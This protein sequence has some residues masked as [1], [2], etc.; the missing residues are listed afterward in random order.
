MRQFIITIAGVLVGLLL[1]TVVAAIWLVTSIAGALN[2]ASSQTAPTP[3]EVV[4]QLDLR[5]TIPDQRGGAG[6]L[7]GGGLNT[8]EIVRK[9]DAAAADPKVKGVYVRA[10]TGGLDPAQTEEIRSALA[11]IR[12][13]KKF[14][15]THMQNDGESNSLLGY[16]A[17][18]GSDELWLQ[19]TGDFMPMGILSQNMYLGGALQKF[20]VQAQ[21]EAREQYKDAVT[22]YTETA[23]TPASKE[24]TTAMLASIY[25]TAIAD[26]A[27]DRGMT[28]AAAKAAI[29]GSPYASADAV[30]LHLAD[31]LG[32]PEDAAQ[33]ALDRAGGKAE[34]L[35]L[36]RY[37][38]PSKSGGAT[39]A[40]VAAE[41]EIVSGPA[42]GPSFGGGGNISSDEISQAL[43][44]AAD[45]DDVKAIVF[46]VSSPGGSAVASDQ[47]SHAVALARQK[48]KKIVVSM[49]PY[50]ASGGYYI[51]AGADS[52]VAEPTTITGSIGIFGGKIVIGPALEHYLGVTTATTSVGSPNIAMFDATSPFT[53]QQRAV[54]AQM[55]DRGYADF[56]GVVAKG[57]H[58]SLDQVHDIAKGRVWTGAQAKERGLVDE[59]GGL[60][61]AI[62]RAKALAGLKPDAKISLKL[63]PQARNPIEELRSLFGVSGE[64]ARA[65][66]AL[67]AIL[68]DERVA[69]AMRAAEID[70]GGLRAEA[71]PM[72]V[73]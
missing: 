40:L 7:F 62:A 26:I 61:V 70:R 36:A 50:A 15:I 71:A 35:D 2:H 37:S 11:K 17:T 5:E 39:I 8:I 29:E 23:P 67:G 63:Y 72:A 9:L 47:I 57:R 54:F 27:A 64:A 33:A 41:G 49:G 6:L 60:D 59:L 42:Q 18:A 3:A 10:A 12:A 21:F 31:K 14:V 38:P 25:D 56:M 34:M 4:L 48:G 55:I 66:V 13:A 24:A 30:K 52:I 1:F 58:M 69:A 68:G 65:A 22:Q 45:D 51:S 32:R 46:R 43:L 73:H 20:H 16:V 44:D 53:N 28:P 19:E